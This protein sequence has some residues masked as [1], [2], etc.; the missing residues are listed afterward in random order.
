MKCSTI[1]PQHNNK[2]AT[3]KAE[4]YSHHKK[5][6]GTYNVKIR[7]THKQK[8]R[9][10]STA[11][12][13]DKDDLT[14]SLKIKNQFIIDQTDLII[15]GYRSICNKNPTAVNSMDIDGVI[16]LL[17]KGDADERFD[18]DFIKYSRDYIAQIDNA[19]NASNYEIALNNLIKFLGRDRLSIHEINTTFVNNWITWIKKQPPPK[20]KTKGQRASSLYPSTLRAVHNAAKKQ[21]NDE[22]A[23]IIKIPYS[24][25]KNADIP[26]YKRSRH[27]VITVEDVKAIANLG[28]RKIIQPGVNR[29]N[30]SRDLFLISFCLLGTNN[31]DLFNCTDYRNGRISYKRQKTKSRREDEAFI[32]IKVEPEIIPLIEKYRDKTGERVFNFYQLYSNTETFTHAINKGLK[33]IGTKLE[34]DDLEFYA[35]RHTLA[36]IAV[37]K[38]GVDKLSVHTALNHV[39]ERMKATDMYIEKDFT[40]NDVANRKLLDY[41]KLDLSNITEP[42]SDTMKQKKQL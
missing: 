41:M 5:Q 33:M 30:F 13:V 31:V 29:F 22:G 1:I 8:K 21:F 3:F 6:D 40:P 34:I 18:L 12:F 38:V 24:P 14:R 37:N 17:E 7:V 27:R 20:G 28:Y 9:Y 23:G 35:A 11:I 25:F 2:M 16:R 36:S 32:S 4:V 39:D 26:K 42:M 15:K 19:G 10:I